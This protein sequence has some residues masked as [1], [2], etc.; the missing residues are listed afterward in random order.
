MSNGPTPEQVA[1]YL[2]RK[3]E[4]TIR[5][6]RSGEAR[7]KKGM[8]FSNWQTIAREEVG[9]ALRAHERR[10]NRQSLALARM[11]LVS[12]SAVVTCGFWGMMVAVDRT[13]GTAAGIATT[14][15][16]AAL[17]ATIAHW[18]IQRAAGS[19]TKSARERRLLHIEE[20]DKRIKRM[21]ADMTKKADRLKDRMEEM[22]AL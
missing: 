4:Q 5:D 11:T 22:G 15:A 19:F 1:E 9:N 2:V 13:W 12:T 18:G 3:L 14:V 16:G 20:I 7:T 8:S 17:I 21:E 6:N 10:Q